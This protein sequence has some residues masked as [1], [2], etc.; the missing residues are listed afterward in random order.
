[1]RPSELDER[2]WREIDRM[3]DDALERPPGERGRFVARITAE[4]EALR[5]EVEALLEAVEL[6]RSVFDDPVVPLLPDLPS[7]GDGDL[8]NRAVG[9]FEIVREIGRG[10]MGR[11]YLAL[12]TRVG[13]MV[14]LKM[15]PPHLGHGPD[16][17]RRFEAEARA[18]SMLDHPNIATLFETDETTDG[19]LYMAFAFYD[20]ETLQSRIAR[21]RLAPRQAVRIATEIA[22][23]LG[24]AHAVGIVH[25]DVKPSNVLITVAGEVKL[26]DFGVA[27]SGREDL[28]SDGLRPGTI[29]YMSP[30][31][32]RGDAI[33]GRADLWSLGAVLH[34]MLTG[35]RPFRGTDPASVLHALLY[36]EP[37]ELDGLGDVPGAALGPVVR[38]LLSKAPDDRYA[39]ANALLGDLQAVLEGRRPVASDTNRR[40]RVAAGLAAAVFLSGA[41]WLT[42]QPG[43]HPVAAGAASTIRSLAVL[44]LE[45]PSADSTAAP[46]VEAVHGALVAEMGTLGGL[47]VLPRTSVLPY[48]DTML[49]PRDIARA[50]GVDALIEG[51]VTRWED[52]VEVSA[53]LIGASPERR[54]WSGRWRRGAG[55][56]FEVA[57]EVTRSVATELGVELTPAQRSRLG[58]HVAVDP[59]AYDAYALGQVTV[60]Q[61]SQ[62]GFA[63][64]ENY[65]RRAMEIDPTFAPPYVALA[66]A[67]GSAMFFGLRSPASTLPEVR[68]LVD[69]ALQIDGNSAEAHATMANVELYG[70]RDWAEAERQARQALELN[71]SLAR[72][73]RVLSEVLV[74]RGRL[75]EALAAIREASELERLVPFSSFRPIVVL[76]YMDDFRQAVDE[77][78]A[79]IEF[80]PGFWQGPWLLC[81]GLI[82]LKEWEEAVNAC[83]RAADASGGTALALRALGFAYA[84]AGRTRAAER[85]VERLE[86]RADTAYVGASNV[87]VVLGAL[88][89]IDEAF[90][91][92]ERAYEQDD[93]A[94]V[95][96][97]EDP[98]VD[99]LRPDPRF[100]ELWREVG[101]EGSPPE[102]VD[103]PAAQSPAADAA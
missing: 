64:A 24:A 85:I 10:G 61:R 28:T 9:P 20:G 13:R 5:L 1:M 65:F 103:R 16:A 22:R 51:A 60:E 43:P 31:H 98:L 79:G 89:R 45:N 52:S 29:A 25:R 18:V 75:P 80:F 34:E 57:G 6:S 11:V 59:R 55:A 39:S 94:L 56:V 44:P 33:D 68:R 36:D 67:Y 3:L 78:R 91:W 21:G 40:G 102:V 48:R 83:E 69:T 73:H 76:I 26:L 93:V 47:R 87:A 2:A 63:Q 99:P 37:K 38:K 53:Q 58:G 41:W 72:A 15:L 12:D 90:A 97:R 70:S 42:S 81:Q 84:E 30:E 101:L 17:R 8:T 19:Q 96:L 32:A 88:G 35:E 27:K 7:P 66:E 74:A 54:L 95:T 62:A 92:M 46:F 49:P 71:P 14:A 86:A 4:D 23:G 77:A 50:L 82:G 100:A